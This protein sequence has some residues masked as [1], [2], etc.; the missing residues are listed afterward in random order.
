MTGS[1]LLCKILYKAFFSNN[2]KA[3]QKRNKKMQFSSNGSP[4]LVDIF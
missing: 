2:R 4:V 1:K 3:K